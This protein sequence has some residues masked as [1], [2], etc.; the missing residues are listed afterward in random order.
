[1]PNEK[2]FAR[3]GSQTCSFYADGLEESAAFREEYKTRLNVV[4]SF[5]MPF[6]DSPDGRLKHI[7]HKKLNT[8]ECCIDAY[9]QFIP[10]GGSTGKHRH[11]AEEVFYVVEGSGY[12]LHW[13]IDFDCKEEF[14]WQWEKEPQRFEWTQGDFVYIPPYTIHQHFNADQDNETRII[15]VTNRILKEMGFDWFDQLENAEGF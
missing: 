1:M 6:E 10:P 7:I 13:D 14:S 12:D 8:M 9:M 2:D 4:K 11:L 5:D 3:K 15:A